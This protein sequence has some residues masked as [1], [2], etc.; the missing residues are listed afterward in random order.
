MNA[1]KLE[2]FLERI[3]VALEELVR[4]VG[5]ENT[6]N[7]AATERKAV[8]A[9]A[10]GEEPGPGSSVQM[11]EAPSMLE[12]FLR[13][14]G[15]Q[16]KTIPTEEPA[17][18]I[19]DRLALYIGERYDLVADLLIRLKR[20]MQ[21]GLPIS[22]SLKGR[23]PLE[24]SSVC[25]L[26]T[27]LHQ[28]AFLED[29]QYSRAPK[30]VLR[31]KTTMLPKA[32]R[33]LSGQWLERFMLQQLKA[34]DTQLTA[35][36]GQRFPFEYL[37]NPQVVLPNGS[38][39]ELDLLAAI[40]PRVYWI[41]AKTGNYQQHVSKYS[42]YVQTF[43]LDA[44]HSF[45]VLADAP[46]SRCDALSSLFGMTVCNLKAARAKLAAVVTSDIGKP[47]WARSLAGA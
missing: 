29:Y 40:G 25:Q 4:L 13:A 39:F 37:M 38:D 15:I 10:Q 22:M 20:A 9:E 11:V 46:E 24:I 2:A 19:I 33:F 32:Q 23:P 43:G 30:Y 28:M 26:C 14:R 21:L 36:T 34:I 41:E 47:E 7:G 18:E 31:A 17:D 3:A 5:G 44:D 35:L 42:R 8:V 6:D 45:M 16:I 1:E 12:A 27:F